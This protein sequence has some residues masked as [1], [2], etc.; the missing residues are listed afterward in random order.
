MNW[1]TFS[2]P[3]SVHFILA[4]SETTIEIGFLSFYLPLCPQSDLI[5]AGNCLRKSKT[6]HLNAIKAVQL[7]AG[8][9]L[10]I[11]TSLINPFGT[12]IIDQHSR[13]SI[14]LIGFY[15]FFPRAE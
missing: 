1:S 15:R 13:E 14:N 11:S 3:K 4:Q 7:M 2:F 5:R 6:Q 12:L 8:K 10:L 9:Q